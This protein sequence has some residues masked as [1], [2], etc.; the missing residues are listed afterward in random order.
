MG[1]SE[2]PHSIIP[3]LQLPL[4]VPKSSLDAVVSVLEKPEQQL[5]IPEP[6]L[7]PLVIP[8]KSL[9]EQEEEAQALILKIREMKS[10]G[11]VIETDEEAKKQVANLQ[12]VLRKVI[13]LK[14]GPE[15]YYL[16][17]KLKFPESMPDFATAGEEGII[18][19]KMAPIDLVPYCV[20]Y[21]LTNV[22]ANFK[23]SKAIFA[24]LCI[25]STC[26]NIN[27]LLNFLINSLSTSSF[28]GYDN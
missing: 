13:V 27:V 25:T 15:P 23:V 19:I 7:L 28:H 5:I 21:F 11:A 3:D 2:A 17:M 18:I 20:Y 24:D 12:N 9:A 14:Y 10:H 22:V 8:E 26:E 4:R 1:L 16:K 6:S